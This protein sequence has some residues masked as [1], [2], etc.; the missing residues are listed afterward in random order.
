VH[1]ETVSNGLIGVDNVNRIRSTGT[2]HL[3]SNDKIVVKNV[4]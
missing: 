4:V 2:V 3:V 1:R